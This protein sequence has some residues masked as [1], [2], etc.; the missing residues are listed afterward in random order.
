M[1]LSGFGG[2]L[3]G[4]LGSGEAA[5]KWLMAPSGEDGEGDSPLQMLM[6]GLG[7]GIQEGSA[8]AAKD[9][10]AAATNAAEV[11]GNALQGMQGPSLASQGHT[12]S[13]QAAMAPRMLMNMASGM[14]AMGVQ[15]SALLGMQGPGLMG[16]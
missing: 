14:Q 6:S 11:Q 5:G 7:T 4:I 2:L 1:D 15:P 3:Q 10:T 8:S 13:L 9:T 12:A 16:Q